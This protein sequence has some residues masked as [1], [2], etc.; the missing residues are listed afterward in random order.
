MSSSFNS[1]ET[2]ISSNWRTMTSDASVSSP[3]TMKT[4]SNVNQ[5]KGAERLFQYF[6]ADDSDPEDYAR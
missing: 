4:N 6:E 5:K 3:S 2:I 1:F